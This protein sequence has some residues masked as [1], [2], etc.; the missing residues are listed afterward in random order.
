[1]EQFDPSKPNALSQ[2]GTFNGNAVTMVAGIAAMEHF[3]A[4]EVARIN[5]LG[6]RLRAGLRAATKSAGIEADVTGYGSMAGLHFTRG[7]VRDYRAAA[8]SDVNL[9]RVV[10]LGLLNE[11]VFAAPRLMFCTSTAM[12]ESVIDDVLARFVRV[13]DRLSA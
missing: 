11:G 13:L 1:M 2:S 5:M 12:D 7:P 4:D 8:R 9:R 3:P 10:H 6:D